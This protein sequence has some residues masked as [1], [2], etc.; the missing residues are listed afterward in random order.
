MSPTFSIGL[1]AEYNVFGIVNSYT[2]SVT[3]KDNNDITKKTDAPGPDLSYGG[4]GYY[5]W[6]NY[7]IPSF[8]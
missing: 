5:V 8:F 3:D 7:S 1:A 4:L 6:I 2:A